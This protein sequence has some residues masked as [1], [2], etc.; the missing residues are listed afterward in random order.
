MHS[1]TRIKRAS[2]HPAPGRGPSK[3]DARHLSTPTSHAQPVHAAGAQVPSLHQLWRVAAG[4][5]AGSPIRQA[6]ASLTTHASSADSKATHLW[7]L[8]CGTCITNAAA[9]R[10][11]EAP[12]AAPT[13]RLPKQ[14]TRA[15][16]QAARSQNHS[17]SH[18]PLASH[19][20]R[21]TAALVGGGVITVGA[22]GS[23]RPEPAPGASKAQQC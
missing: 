19:P 11:T 18:P 3:P 20:V 4:L 2:E 14:G 6:M 15:R 10:R 7:S 22:Q 5:R 16:T 17:H 1:I 12:A 21:S 9:A 13:S 8:L 23:C